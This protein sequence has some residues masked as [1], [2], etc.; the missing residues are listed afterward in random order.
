MLNHGGLHAELSAQLPEIAAAL[1][2][3]SAENGGKAK[4]SL[5]LKIGFELKKGIYEINA[6]FET[7]LPKVARDRTIAWGT[8]D[9]FFSPQ[10]P[11]QV[12]MFSGPRAVVD[13]Y[14]GDAV[15]RDV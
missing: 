9:N 1:E 2:N 14:Q 8:H 6:D 7:K 13:A 10:D 4:G 11:R 5:V 12:E 15:A 3:H